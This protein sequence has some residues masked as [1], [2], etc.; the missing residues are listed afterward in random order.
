MPSLVGVQ[1]GAGHGDAI[2]R[3]ARGRAAAFKVVGAGA[4]TVVRK[5]EC[6]E[7][8]PYFGHLATDEAKPG[9]GGT[10]TS[11]TTSARARAGGG[12]GGERA[13]PFAVLARRNQTLF[14]EFAALAKSAAA[15][16]IIPKVHFAGGLDDA[17]GG[18]ERLL[19]LHLFWK[20]SPHLCKS[21]RYKNWSGGWA[22]YKEWADKN[23]DIET[24]S[25]ISLV[26][27]H[28]DLP[29]VINRARAMS[30]DDPALADVVFSTIHK[31]K[32]LDWPHVYVCGDLLW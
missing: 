16:G 7:R 4:G 5:V 8:P 21:A 14:A 9:L 27:A 26:E 19:D 20:G 18:L 32:G 6:A 1:S 30:V 28:E 3:A 29:N 22:K 10:A 11:T 15:T 12:A 31:S 17:W 13:G 24:L 2:A 23:S 25:K